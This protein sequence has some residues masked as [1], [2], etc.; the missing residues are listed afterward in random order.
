MYRVPWIALALAVVAVVVLVFPLVRTE[1]HLKDVRNELG[2]T[3]EQ[4]VK[5]EKVIANLKTELDE[6][7][8]ART[9]FQGSLDEATISIEQLRKELDAAQS[10][11]K[12]K[13]AHEQ[14]LTTEL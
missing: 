13:E 14:E 9:Q 11:L 1:Q 12:E 5:L 8:T 6:A 2:R 10:Q 3:N 4:V 7:N